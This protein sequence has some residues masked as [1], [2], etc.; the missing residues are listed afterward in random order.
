MLNYIHHDARVPA[1]R[2]G[3]LGL[4]SSTGGNFSVNN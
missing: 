2:Q 4:L 1:T 3:D